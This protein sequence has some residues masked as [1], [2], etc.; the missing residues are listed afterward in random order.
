MGVALG[1]AWTFVV[2]IAYRQRAMRPFNG[3]VAC[4]IFFGMLAGTFAWQ[5]AQNIDSDL[6]ALKLPLPQ[7]E[8]ADKDWWESEWR[9][10]PRQRTQLQSVP[11]P[12]FNFQF[13]GQAEN[14]SRVLSDHGWQEAE[15][16]NWRWLLLTINPEPTEFTLP[17]L[18]RDY[19]GHTDILLLHRL[20]GDPTAQETL[21]IWDSGFRLKP[22]G[23]TVFL[24]QISREVMVQR[25][26]FFS[27][28]R[29]GPASSES[30]ARFKEEVDVL[31]VRREDGGFLLIR[32]P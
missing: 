23:E 1:M 2:G 22:G 12:E 14:L 9:Q 32:E 25:L 28:W 7:S 8:I 26:M 16:A 3:L 13:A 27:Y 31:Q 17:P 24:G 29:A 4:L 21:R 15:P 30:L 20:G 6:A 19:L 5:V 18:R 10:L 11:A